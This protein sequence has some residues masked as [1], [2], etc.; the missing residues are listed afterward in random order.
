MSRA[1]GIAT[2]GDGGERGCGHPRVVVVGAGFAGFH[3]ARSLYRRL[4]R[5]AEIVLVNPTDYF[6]YLPLL[7]EVAAGILE[8]R[9]VTVSLPATLPGVR[10]VARHGATPSTSTAGPSPSVD[11][12]GGTSRLDYDRLVLAV[13]QRQQAAADP[14]RAPSTRTASAACPRRSTCATTSIRQI[15]LADGTDDA[16]ERDGPAARSSW[17]APATPAPRSPRRACCSPTRWRAHAP[18]LRGAAGALAAARHRRR[19]CCPGCD[20]RLVAR[21]RTAS[22]RGRGVEVRTGVPR[23][24]RP[25]RTACGSPTASMVPTRSLIWCVGVRPDPL[26]ETLGLPTDAGPAGRRRVPDRAGPPG[27]VRRAATR[28]RCPT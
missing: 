7:P 24:R 26:V 23:S 3:A 8:P 12:E 1:S 5:P 20:E 6:L 14:G 28:P 25:P 18:R 22:L 27:D 4:R 17:S 15:E 10:L 19:G 9:R 16:A 11:P 2:G 21:P 13:R